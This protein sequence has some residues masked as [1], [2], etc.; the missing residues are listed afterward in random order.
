MSEIHE[1][2]EHAEHTAHGGHEGHGHDPFMARVAMTMA[3]IA[4]ALAVIAVMG[5][6][7][8]NTVLQLQG[9]ANRFLTEAAAY[10]VQSSNTF[11]RYQFKRNRME[12]QER[13]ITFAKLFPIN[14]GTEGLR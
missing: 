2:L 10:K 9:D 12:E 6:R 14:P 3:I 11:T 1:H 7:T 4:A 13:S 8:H 5:H